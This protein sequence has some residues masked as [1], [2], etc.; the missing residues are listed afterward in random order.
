[1]NITQA[2]EQL[3]PEIVAKLSF[4]IALAALDHA[5]VPLNQDFESALDEAINNEIELRNLDPLVDIL[6]TERLIGFIDGLTV[7]RKLEVQS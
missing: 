3:D 5:G 7:A 6:V 4:E 1:M 2:L